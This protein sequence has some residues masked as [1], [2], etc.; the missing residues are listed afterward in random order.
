MQSSSD[1]AQYR[2]DS[3]RPDSLSAVQSRLSKRMPDTA[4][5]HSTQGQHGPTFHAERNVLIR[6][7]DTTTWSLA[8]LDWTFYLRLFPPAIFILYLPAFSTLVAID[9]RFSATTPLK[10]RDARVMWQHKTARRHVV[11]C[12]RSVFQWAQCV[13]M[14]AV[15]SNERSVLRWP[16]CAPISAVCSN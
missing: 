8:K 14:S 2:P 12:G 4:D 5:C 11:G 15:C 13:S 1:A 10:N 6:G 3:T 9:F 16:Q 7:Q